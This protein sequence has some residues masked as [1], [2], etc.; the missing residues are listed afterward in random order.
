MPEQVP[1]PDEVVADNAALTANSAERA[2]AAAADAIDKA[3]AAAA[4]LAVV[5]AE[6]TRQ[7][8]ERLA[9]WQTKIQSENETLRGELS[10]TKTALETR[11]SETMDAILSIQSRLDKPPA[12]PASPAQGSSEPQNPEANPQAPAEPPP[13]PSPPKK[14][15]HRWI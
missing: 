7:S 1:T 14:K 4:G 15:A 11:L 9:E 5:A 12:S 6:E 10:Q 2:Q 13:P 3:Q 8:E